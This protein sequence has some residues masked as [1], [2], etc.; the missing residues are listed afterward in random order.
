[1]HLM[2]ALKASLGWGRKIVGGIIRQVAL[3]LGEGEYMYRRLLWS[4][5][6]QPMH[7]GG[8]KPSLGAH[9]RQNQFVSYVSAKKNFCVSVCIGKNAFVRQKFSIHTMGKSG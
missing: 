5:K 6:M 8:P 9:W 2:V 7:V 4:P 1:M 3:Q